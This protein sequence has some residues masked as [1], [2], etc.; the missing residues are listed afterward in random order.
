[1]KYLLNKNWWYAE[2]AKNFGSKRWKNE[3]LQFFEIFFACINI[4]FPQ[5]NTK[6]TA[7]FFPAFY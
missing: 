4:L 7:E 6:K 3:I 1:M 2:I 5:K